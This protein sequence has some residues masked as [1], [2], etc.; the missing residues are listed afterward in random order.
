M[1]SRQD[2]VYS[3][4][5]VHSYLAYS[6]S[7]K[8]LSLEH[9]TVTLNPEKLKEYILNMLTWKKITSGSQFLSKKTALRFL[10]E[11][12]CYAHLQLAN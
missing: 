11:H 2:H 4:T 1:I 7:L 12:I 8:T 3:Y 10:S 5:P 9:S 6:S